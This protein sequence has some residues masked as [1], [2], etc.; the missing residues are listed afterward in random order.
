M[1]WTNTLVVFGEAGD[2]GRSRQPAAEPAMAATE[3]RPARPTRKTRVISDW[4]LC[5]RFVI[6]GLLGDRALE[7]I[8]DG[9]MEGPGRPD[10]GRTDQRSERKCPGR[11]LSIAA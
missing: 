2:T 7:G 8:G 9:P 3:A 4:G 10:A 1:S 11:L 6:A 5:E